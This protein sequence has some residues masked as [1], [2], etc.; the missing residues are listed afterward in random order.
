[1]SQTKV[2]LGQELN[3]LRCK[4]KWLPRK[5]LVVVCPNCKSP[6]W[7]VNRNEV[8]IC[9]DKQGYVT[10]IKLEKR[11]EKQEMYKNY[12]FVIQTGFMC[13]D[14]VKIWLEDGTEMEINPNRYRIDTAKFLTSRKIKTISLEKKIKG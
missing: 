14:T 1:M 7:N 5:E 6:Y 8:F 13:Q 9:V 2:P 4:Y 12:P 11:L 10:R 3:C